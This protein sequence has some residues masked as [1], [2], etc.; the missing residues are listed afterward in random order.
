MFY[1][2]INETCNKT[3]YLEIELENSLLFFKSLN[4]VQESGIVLQEGAWETVK[5]KIKELWTKFKNWVKG[6]WEKIKSIFTKKK[7]TITEIKEAN[8]KI[9]K[10]EAKK[11]KNES[12]SYIKEFSEGSD[13]KEIK[14]YVGKSQ[15]EAEKI[16]NEYMGEFA[17]MISYD[18]ALKKYGNETIPDSAFDDY[19]NM[20]E[21]YKEKMANTEVLNQLYIEN[22]FTNI[23]DINQLKTTADK[24]TKA[25]EDLDVD[26]NITRKFIEQFEKVISKLEEGFADEL[27]KN[28]TD[29]DNMVIIDG[30]K[31]SVNNYDK[32]VSGCIS[33]LHSLIGFLAKFESINIKYLNSNKIAIKKLENYIWSKEREEAQNYSGAGYASGN[34]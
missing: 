24:I 30:M 4:I 20:C 32:M 1:G 3:D 21:K 10:S 16:M 7:S 33:G 17:K 5:T 8:N 28:N 2:V 18:E 12:F 23:N 11:S 25:S 9:Q 6:I 14:W 34:S 15:S 29:A 26:S 27:K 31:M 19:A 22:T 13:S